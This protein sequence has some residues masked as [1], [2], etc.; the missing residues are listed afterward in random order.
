MN[1]AGS[2]HLWHETFIKDFPAKPEWKRHVTV[3]RN[4]SKYYIKVAIKGSDLRDKTVL[5]GHSYGHSFNL[6][7]SRQVFRLFQG[8]FSTRCNLVLPISISRT[9]ALS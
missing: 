5:A 2:M 1:V 6:Y 7:G 3:R 4:R 8:D 9:L